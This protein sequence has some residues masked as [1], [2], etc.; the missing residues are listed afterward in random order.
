MNVFQTLIEVAMIFFSKSIQVY[1]GASL[2]L[3]GL[4]FYFFSSSVIF[5]VER[6]ADS[7]I[8]QLQCKGHEKRD[9]LLVWKGQFNFQISQRIE[10][11]SSLIQISQIVNG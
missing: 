5:F 2:L 1:A 7:T 8:E 4:T 11:L 6:K 3:L 9:R 10:N